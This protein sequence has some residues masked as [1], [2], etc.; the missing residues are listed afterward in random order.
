M[1]TIDKM[2]VKKVPFKKKVMHKKNIVISGKPLKE[3]K[4]V[5]ILLHGRGG[6]A[7]DILSFSAHL[8]VK[9]FA[10][11]APH[12]TNNSWYPS[13]FVAP[14]ADNEPW[15]SSALG[16]IKDIVDDLKNQG[17]ASENIYFTGFSQGA[18]LALEFVARNATKFGGVAAF[19]GG[20]IGDKIYDENYKGDFNNTAIFI[21]SS[22]P[23]SHI[24]V[25]RVRASTSILKKMN[26][27]VIEKIYDNM[28][29]TINEDE[30]NIANTHV[31]SR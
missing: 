1:L 16:L 27:D 18:C 8:N 11:I 26:A 31:F 20:V 22:N 3:A 2:P 21:G 9:D 14:V 23:D 12:A 4:K 24:P 25:E 7:Q 10:L 17:V 5:L 6:D 13:S 28:G 30:I 19:S 29:H 15:L